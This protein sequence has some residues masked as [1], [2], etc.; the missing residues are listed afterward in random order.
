MP[1][2]RR[3]S[4]SADSSLGHVALFR[5]IV[6]KAVINVDPDSENRGFYKAFN[7][8]G[9]K[10]QLFEMWIPERVR[11]LKNADLA[12]QIDW[13]KIPWLFANGRLTDTKPNLPKEFKAWR[14]SW[15][16][17]I[18]RFLEALIEQLDKQKPVATVI[19]PF[20]GADALM[21]K[22]LVQR[23]DEGLSA[24][25]FTAQHVL[26][27][28]EEAEVSMPIVKDDDLSIELTVCRIPSNLLCLGL[29]TCLGC[30][31]SRSYL[32]P[33]AVKDAKASLKEQEY[34][35]LREYLY[36]LYE[37]C[38]LENVDDDLSDEQ[39]EEVLRHHQEAFLSGQQISLLSLKNDHDARRTLVDSLRNDIQKQLERQTVST[40][41]PTVIELVH[42]PGT[43]GSTIA[44]RIL[45][46]LHGTYPCAIVRESQIQSNEEEEKRF[47]DISLRISAMEELTS[48]APLILLDGE[49]SFF[50]RPGSSRKIAEM[51][52]S[53]GKKKAVILHCLRG[54]DHSKAASPLSA[55][56]D[57]KLSPE[58]RR[59]FEQK[60]RHLLSST[61]KGLS[62][63]FHF[64]LWA[65]LEEF[66]PRLKQIVS[67]SLETFSSSDREIIRFV[68]LMQRFAGRS[69]PPALVYTLFLRRDLEGQDPPGW[70]KNSLYGVRS[71]TY[72]DIYR[73]LS[74]NIKCLL[75][76]NKREE[77]FAYDLHHVLV[78]DTVLCRLLGGKDGGNTLT[79][80][81][82]C[83]KELLDLIETELAE[84]DYV[85]LFEDLFLHNKDGDSNLKFSVLVDTLRR[86]VSDSDKVGALLSRAASFFRMYRF[87]SHLSRFYI[88][89]YDPP[90]FEKALET[91]AKGFEV[92]KS[93]GE[94]MQLWDARG[95]VYRFQLQ[96]AI[97][98]GDIH[99]V[100]RLEEMASLALKAYGNA[101]TS[102]PSWPNPFVGKV[103]V[104]M[105]CIE[106]IL[107]NECSGEIAFLLQYLT[108]SSPPCFRGCLSECFYLIE[109]VQRITA[110]QS[111]M[112]A[113][114]TVSLINEC[115][116][117]LCFVE[118]GSRSTRRK[119]AS[120]STTS[121]SSEAIVK[122]WQEL[123]ARQR[124]L[125]SISN[126][127][128]WKRCQVTLIMHHPEIKLDKLPAAQLRFLIKLLLELVDQHKEVYFIPMLF[129]VGSHLKSDS[130][131]NLI[132]LDRCIHLASIWQQQKRDSYDPDPFTW[133]HLYMFYFL[134]ILDDGALEFGAK[135][136]EAVN[137]C[138]DLSQNHINRLK[139]YFYLGKGAG[140]SAL[141][142]RRALKLP[143][144]ESQLEGF[145]RKESRGQL[146][147]LK[148]RIKVR[149]GA[150]K[151]TYVFI[152]LVQGP[153]VEIYA[154]RM[155]EPGR[156]F[157]T[158]QQ[159]T[160]VLSFHLRGPTA[161]GVVLL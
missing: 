71:P 87:Y 97:R 125:Q 77:G 144:D 75:V 118:S 25:K 15:L 96:R 131:N 119:N 134:K 136:F 12:G 152:E 135:Y 157:Q 146:K 95:L 42:K 32:L 79:L 128:E 60:Y 104:Y 24:N 65:F 137:K 94:R 49:S 115:K 66:K 57:V 122:Q 109:I 89:T 78:A 92:C 51:L 93:G 160:F 84:P 10:Q 52:M 98:S 70:Q 72:D 110:T 4:D 68:A 142:Y 141:V 14:A 127:K 154:G 53:R 8:A 100:G 124:S 38:E 148:G 17:P 73:M 55:K 6:W 50:R 103:Q 2:V 155:G 63:T 26:I 126:E 139:P 80:L 16:N 140:L 138:R 47:N 81:P 30:A 114:H 21:I 1:I 85:D 107:K 111:L 112:D 159:V 129:R 88:Y 36:P 39:M 120:A 158:D 61:I 145:W 149:S 23:L 117:K 27:N 29:V 83:I 113:E 76:Q 64:P 31:Q 91:I 45:W 123:M 35:Y 62:R 22:T 130:A 102:P 18:G 41:T 161:H 48:A 108:T 43:G 40:A 7:V 147:E 121:T 46:E 106:W 54:N 86:T 151:K 153:G 58:D 11:D 56:V 67:S 90:R 5:Q 105:S 3:E 13:K 33:S 44:R 99:S 143:S 82:R 133:F 132:T 69:V 37:R 150:R 156:D 28:T 20:K 19:M 116:A 74:D 101:V 34:L 9:G 59:K